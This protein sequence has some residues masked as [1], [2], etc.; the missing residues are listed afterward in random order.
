MFGFIKRSFFTRLAFLLTLA[1]AN[2]LSCI[3]MSNQK[4]EANGDDPVFFS[5]RIK[6]SQCSGSS[7][8]INNPFAKLCVTD[9]V[10]NLNVKVCNIVSGTNK[11][12]R[13]EW[14][15]TCKCKCRFTSSV[16]N[17]KQRWNDDKCRC[18]CK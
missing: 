3:S 9:I 1:S 18:K 16:C 4:C 17:N 13:I 5:F 10:K 8:N 2:T 6:T 12:S 15:E 7:Y 14:H 11:K